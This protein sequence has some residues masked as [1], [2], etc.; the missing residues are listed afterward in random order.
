MWCFWC[1]R[2]LRQRGSCCW[3]RSVMSWKTDLSTRLPT[4]CHGS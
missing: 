4:A 1:W 3:E 2:W